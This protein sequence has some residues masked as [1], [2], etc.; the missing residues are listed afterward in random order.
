[1]K[2]KW[3]I[4]VTQHGLAIEKFQKERELAYIRR[5]EYFLEKYGLTELKTNKPRTALEP[6][7]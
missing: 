4:T 7:N 6:S 5:K 1:M 3:E 2:N